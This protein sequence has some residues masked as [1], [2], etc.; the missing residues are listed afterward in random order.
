MYIWLPHASVRKGKQIFPPH[1]TSEG[2]SP[3]GFAAQYFIGRL[4]K[5]AKDPGGEWS[6]Q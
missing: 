5:W 6:R 4:V 1:I 2:V 3:R